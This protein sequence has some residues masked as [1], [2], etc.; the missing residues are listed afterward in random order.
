MSFKVYFDFSCPFSYD[1]RKWVD[2]ADLGYDIEW[3]CFL[4]AQAHERRPD[5]RVFDHTDEHPPG[6]AALAGYM[7]LRTSRDPNADAF[8]RLLLEA[9]QEQGLDIDD[10]DNLCKLGA[11][12]GIDTGGLAAAFEDPKVIGNLAAEHED[13]VMAYAMFGTPTIVGPDHQSL[14]ARL[15]A[16]PEDKAT[17]QRV[18]KS[19]IDIALTEPAVLELRRT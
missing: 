9:R 14:Y 12:L 11:D 4:N 10:G 8:H 3:R 16:P 17:A 6:L 18:V 2:L 7:W 1:F 19:V 5:W 13:A 15:G